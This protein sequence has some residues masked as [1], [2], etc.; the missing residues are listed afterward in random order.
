[1]TAISSR[2]TGAILALAA[3]ALLVACAPSKPVASQPGVVEDPAVAAA[4]AEAEA[5]AK[6]LADA[7]SAFEAAKADP[8]TLKAL[9]DAGNP[10]AIYNR[11]TDELASQDAAQKQLAFRDME[12][13]ADAGVPDA[14]L[15]VGQRYAEGSDGYPWKPNSGIIM[16]TRAAD[17][18]HAQAMYVLG[19]LYEK[20]GPM[21]DLAKARDWYEK[22]KAAGWKDA[23]T[24]LA[25]M[26]AAS[27]NHEPLPD[28]ATAPDC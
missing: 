23:E 10:W 4:R 3:A 9:I 16:V 18:G 27:A 22:A 15:W 26:E 6:K 8:E 7:K 20:P 24:A 21:H 12:D 11:A 25:Q 28:C 19:F 14:L 17:A 1:M 13:A 5:A 2:L